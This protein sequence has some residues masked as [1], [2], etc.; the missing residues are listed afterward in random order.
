[1]KNKLTILSDIHLEFYTNIIQIDYIIDMIPECKYLVLAGDL[2]T[3]HYIDNLHYFIKKLENKC[4]YIIAISGHTHHELDI[5]KNET[6]YLSS[7][8]GYPTEI[9]YNFSPKTMV[10]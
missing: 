3:L 7:P 1:M 6:R 4:K 2:C 5:I 9:G 8:L 10:I